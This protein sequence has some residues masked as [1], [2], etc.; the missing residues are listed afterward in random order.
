MAD[1]DVSKSREADQSDSEEEED[2]EAGFQAIVDTLGPVERWS[3]STILALKAAVNAEFP[4]AYWHERSEWTERAV[5]AILSPHQGWNW[6]KLKRCA[7]AEYFSLPIHVS[8]LACKAPLYLAIVAKYA[9]DYHTFK[10]PL[11]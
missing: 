1:P 10:R 8:L 7:K 9:E 3:N 6:R 2:E 5:N 11:L 4:E